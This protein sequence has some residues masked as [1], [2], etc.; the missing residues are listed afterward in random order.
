MNTSK[1]IKR[2][3]GVA[4]LIALAVVLQ[5]VANYITFGPVSINLALIPLVICAIIYGPY[6]GCLVGMVI[7]VIILTA[8]ST[9]GFL[10][11][12]AFLTV[13]LCLLKTG[14]AGL[15]S[16]FVFKLLKKVNV[17][18]AVVIAAILVPIINSGLFLLGSLLWFQGL[19]GTNAKEAFST[20]VS[21][22]ISINFAIELAINAILSPSL[23]YLLK[24]LDKK[25][26][27][28]LDLSK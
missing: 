17:P 23:I 28:E 13:V 10:G 18:L 24:T 7:G 5:I 27:L 25:F 2:M 16:G 15:A 9:Q 4:S 6:S 11:Y 20:L 22:V 19:F 12:N 3:V 1:R 21:I 14:L 8:P 26:D